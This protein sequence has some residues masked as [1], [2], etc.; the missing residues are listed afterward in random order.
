MIKLSVVILNYNT[1]DLLEQ[2][3]SSLPWHLVEQNWLEVI[4]VDNNSNDG[5]VDMVKTE[6][7]QAIRVVNS[8]NLG[9]AAGNNQGLIAATGEQLML[10]NSDTI[11]Q[12][13]ALEKL[14]EFLD[15]NPKAGLVTP[16][17]I[18]SNGQLDWSSHRGKP[19]LW[20]S[21]MYFSGLAKMFPK[22][23]LVSGY[24]QSWKDIS[25]TH[26]VDVISGGAMCF[27]RQVYQDVGGL[28]EAFFM[29]AE[30]VDYC[31]RVKAAGWQIH[32]YPEAEIIHLK[33]Q[34][35]TRS[36]NTKVRRQTNHH[37]Y[38]TMKLYFRKHYP[39]YPRWSLRLIDW[40]IDLLARLRG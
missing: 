37:F 15:S 22:L 12:D 17:L 35:G 36:Q 5:S 23:K 24:H 26:Q 20:N 34:S 10:L 4:V 13:Q 27:K 38:Q 8:K 18:L 30:D 1:K 29:Y 28:D 6:Y 25:T 16:K 39:H 3:L 9:F 33:G 2:T 40:S 21:L 7:P 32:F 19:T 31:I 11:V 14:V